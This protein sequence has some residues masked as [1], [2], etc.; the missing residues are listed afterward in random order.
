MHNEGKF[1]AIYENRG[2]HIL[3]LFTDEVCAHYSFHQTKEGRE[4]LLSQLLT[5][6]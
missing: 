2:C 6:W 5:L 4:A 1:M 3:N